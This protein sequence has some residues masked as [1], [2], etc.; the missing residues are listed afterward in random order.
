[1]WCE[2]LHLDTHP[3]QLEAAQ[4][5]HA[6]AQCIEVPAMG[7]VCQRLYLILVQFCGD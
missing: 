6:N 4:L 3:L 7:L 5:F 2:V 1:M